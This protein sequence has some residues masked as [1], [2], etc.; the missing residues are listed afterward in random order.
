MS[1]TFHKHLV[2]FDETSTDKDASVAELSWPHHQYKEGEKKN[3]K[4]QG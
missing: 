2:D 3:N 1:T 4:P